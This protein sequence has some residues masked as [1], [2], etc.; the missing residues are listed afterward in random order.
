MA[1]VTCT[2]ATPRTT[3]RARAPSR[4]GWKP[5][6]P[7][8]GWVGFEPTNDLLAQERHIRTAVGRGYADV[9]PIRGVFNSDATTAMAVAVSVSDHMP[10]ELAELVLPDKQS[11]PRDLLALSADNAQMKGWRRERELQQQQQQ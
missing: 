3:D 4:P 11:F 10:P 1:V 7:A 8:T 5:G 9:P 6:C 2:V